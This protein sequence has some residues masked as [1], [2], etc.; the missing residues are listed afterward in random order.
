MA[1]F[2]SA[3]GKPNPAASVDYFCTAAYNGI[4]KSVWS[5]IN[6]VEKATNLDMYQTVLFGRHDPQ[7]KKIQA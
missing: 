4:R 6:R 7:G 3:R 2:Y 1:E 5:E